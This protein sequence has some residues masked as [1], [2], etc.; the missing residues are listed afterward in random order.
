MVLYGRRREAALRDIMLA[1]MFESTPPW[2]ARSKQKTLRFRGMSIFN[3]SGHTCSTHT[4][5]KQSS[6]IQYSQSNKTKRLVALQAD[7]IKAKRICNFQA[8]TQSNKAAVRC[9]QAYLIRTQQ[10]YAFQAFNSVRS[11]FRF[12]KLQQ[13][14]VFVLI[15]CTSFLSKMQIRFTDFIWGRL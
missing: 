1:N 9:F 7:S 11:H 5:P 2:R 4:S 8:Y 12:Y 13:R 10:P 3:A 14:A 6:Y 15:S